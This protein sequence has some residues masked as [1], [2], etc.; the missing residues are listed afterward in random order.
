[1]FWGFSLYKT[2]SPCLMT[3]SRTF[4]LLKTEAGKLSCPDLISLSFLLSL[5]L[6][7]D[8]GMRG[9]V[10]CDSYRHDMGCIIWVHTLEDFIPGQ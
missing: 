9:I 10:L 8:E 5:I 4:H 6:V 7:G 2:L 3:Q 1:M